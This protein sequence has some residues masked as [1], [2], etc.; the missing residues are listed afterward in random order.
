MSFRIDPE[1]A[2]QRSY[3]Q[4][5][6]AN[7]PLAA[8]KSEFFIADPELCYLDGNSLGR[9]PKKTIEQ[10]NSFLT[11]EW[12]TELVDGWSH[13][14][15]QA[16]PAG[17]LLAKAA[18]GAGPGQTLVCDTTSVNFYQLCLAAIS[19][20]PGRK[21]IIID[22]ANFPTDRYILEGIAKS[23]SLNLV[24]LDT[25][26]M[27]GPGAVVINS[28]AELITPEELE[29][30]LS[31]DVALVTL[32][33]INYRSGARQPMKQINAL[34][35]KYGA[36]VVWDCSHAVGSIELEFEKNDVQLAVGC[37][38]KYGNSGPGSPAW[39][40]VSK[41]IQTEL[42]VP[43]QG[44]FA[45]EKQFEMGPFFEPAETI[46]RYQI[47]S[48]SIIGIRGVEVAFEMIAR[49]GID[50]IA[51]KAA[52]GTDLMIALH[53]AWLTPLGFELGTPRESSMRGGH[54]IIKHP[55]AK[56]IAFALRK[57]SNVIPDYREPGSI[58][59]AISPLATSYEE[60][61]EGFARL[62]DLVGSGQ[63]K[64][65]SMDGNRVT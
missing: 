58:R 22:S 1:A 50:K 16:Q 12:G 6:D 59:L 61:Y 5:L 40:F 62:R 46:R 41:A 39:L 55:D 54:I 52:M 51:A 24:T 64:T 27:G 63:Y 33:A 3:A 48:P 2:T 20:R 35:R 53:D 29:K 31:E 9:L 18:L 21:T 25:D 15:D 56:L 14:I 37:T 47:A 42:R 30:H 4:S 36:L 49:A 19:A 8:F 38:Y 11:N 10:V 57:L 45:Q 17:D 65:V 44:W 32:Q 34:A 60:V 43:I 13:W 23:H 26:G 28:T 7:D